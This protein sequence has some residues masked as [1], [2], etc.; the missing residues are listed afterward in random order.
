MIKSSLLYDYEV[1]VPSNT[2]G[3]HTLM[4]LLMTSSTIPM[5]SRR[6]P[7]GGVSRRLRYTSNQIIV[8]AT[9]CTKLMRYQD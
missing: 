4:A 2:L 7:V 8:V 5:A 9:G 1:G 6:Y 3:M